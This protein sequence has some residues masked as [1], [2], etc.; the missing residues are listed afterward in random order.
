[1][2][3][4]VALGAI[5]YGVYLY[6]WPVYVV[7]DEQRTGLPDAAL[8]AVRLGLTLLLAVVSFRLLERP[9]RVG[10][11]RRPAFTGL[12]ACS[13]LALIVAVVP[14]DTTPYWAPSND[15]ATA[16]TLAPVDSVVELRVVTTT[17]AT[18]APPTTDTTDPRRRRRRRRRPSRRPPTVDP[19][20]RPAAA[21]GA[22]A[23]GAH[24]RHRRLH[25]DG[26]RRRPAGVGS[27][28]IQTWPR[29]RWRDRPACGFVRGGHSD[30]DEVRQV[31]EECADL[32]EERLPETLRNLQPD[33]VVG[34]VTVRDIEDRVWD[35]AEGPLPITDPRFAERLIADYDAA[36]AGVRGRRRR[37]RAV[38]AAAAARLCRCSTQ[39]ATDAYGAALAEVVA[40]HPGRAAVVDLRGWLARQPEIPERPDGLH[41]SPEAAARLAGDYL[42]P[43]VVAAAVT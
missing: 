21:D 33:V 4:L 29:S 14:L 15:E 20:R 27:R 32:L 12:A 25:G 3:P 16:A 26:H 11:L 42:G 39:L 35:D 19:V 38:G 37:P 18:T 10:G 40:R 28:A 43:V 6:H 22:L 1:M 34:M 24:R 31:R 41:W 5:S 23:S 17:T 8:F 13:A 30:V 7:L 36:T 9:I 2:R